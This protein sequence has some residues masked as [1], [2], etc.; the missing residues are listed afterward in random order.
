MDCDDEMMIH[1]FMEVEAIATADDEEH[2]MILTCLLQLQVDEQKK[3][4]AMWRFELWKKE[5]QA[6]AED[7][8]SCHALHQI[9]YR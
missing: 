5:H 7:G 9:F 8:G 2:F 3:S 4:L 6:K 1:Q